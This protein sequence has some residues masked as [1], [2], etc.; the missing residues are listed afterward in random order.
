MK[1]SNDGLIN[2]QEKK[3]DGDI[4]SQIRRNLTEI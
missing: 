2:P 1:K 4:T 3:S